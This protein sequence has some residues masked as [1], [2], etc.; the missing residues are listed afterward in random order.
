M[1]GHSEERPVQEGGRKTDS[2]PEIVLFGEEILSRVRELSAAVGD[3]VQQA[4]QQ[5]PAPSS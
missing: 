1:T 2:V 4:I 5:Q 3:R